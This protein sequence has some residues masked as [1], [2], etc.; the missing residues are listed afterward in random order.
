[1]N[2]WKVRHEGSPV[3]SHDLTFEQV[4]QALLEGR[5]SP[6]DEVKG[7]NDADWKTIED[8]PA[9]AETC[10]DMDLPAPKVEEDESK[11]DM[12]AL[13]DVCLVLLV[14][15]ILTTSYASL[16]K[17]MEAASAQ[18]NAKRGARPV[19]QAEVESAMI[20]CLVKQTKDEKTG[21]ERTTIS[22]EK[23]EVQL[24][25]PERMSRRDYQEQ[26]RVA[27]ARELTKTIGAA[28]KRTLLLE[29]DRAVPHGVI[30]AIQDAAKTAHM[31]G[32][33]L[34]VP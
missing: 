21:T 19:K 22:I 4:M 11:L 3:A 27:V 6:V 14:F 5:F 33:A 34:L 10:A 18:A 7:P 1:M 20:Y 30:V 8:H 28:N 17:I 25:D 9:F 26:V 29:H 31:D 12:N 2:I 24:P 32:V 23:T 16:Q 15:F 13:I